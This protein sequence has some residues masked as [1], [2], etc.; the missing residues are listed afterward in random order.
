MSQE[1]NV[2]DQD[3]YEDPPGS[4]RRS[5]DVVRQ[6]LWVA[7]GVLGVAAWAVGLAAVAPLG[8]VV[9]LSVLAGAVAVLGLLPGQT[10]R[11]WLA[12]AVAVTALADAVTI[13]VTAGGATWVL[14]VID[15]LVGLQ[16]VVAVVALLLEPRESAVTQST[17]GSDYAAYAQYVQA[18]QDYAEQYGS[19]WPDQYAAAG[20]AD[21]AGHAQATASG[22]LGGEQ[23]AWDAMQARYS[24]HVSTAAPAS[25]RLSR[26]ADDGYLDDAG[27]PGVGRADRPY[28]ARGQASPGSASTSPGAY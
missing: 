6:S 5:N 19:Q 4:V 28:E 12:V 21:A 3:G 2:Y 13:T 15:V 20:V 17:L 23:D 14:V 18:Y 7:T 9:S 1:P 27:L 10:A 25:E 16:A 26:R 24:Q 22:T 11:G 8:L